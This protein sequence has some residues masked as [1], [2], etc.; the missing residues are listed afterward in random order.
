VLYLAIMLFLM[1]YERDLIFIGGKGSVGP[2]PGDYKARM[3]AVPGAGRL[4]VWEIPAA[5]AREPTFVFFSGNGSHITDFAATGETFHARGWGVVLASYRGYS[6]NL[7]DPSEDGLMQD[8]RAILASLPK[9]GTLI[10]WGHSL[11]SGVAARMA[12]EHR[13]SGLVLESAYTSVV[14]VAAR[15][16]WIFPVHWLMRDRF[17][18][19]T[20]LDKIKVPVLLIHGTDDPVVPFDMGQTLAH[21]FGVR[22]TFIPIDGVGHVPH[23]IDLSPLVAKWLA[24]SRLAP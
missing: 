22:A 2:A 1:T 12:S 3:V 6:G 20:L 24:K 10:L 21:R 15:Q 5:S 19:E 18:T 16:F 13:G 11:G 9:H 4:L 8:A 17:E 7:G 14:N 23:Q